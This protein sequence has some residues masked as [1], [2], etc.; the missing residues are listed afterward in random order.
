VEFLD[1]SSHVDPARWL[2]T[3]GEYREF[4]TAASGTAI[5]LKWTLVEH[6]LTHGEPAAVI[7][8]DVDV[9]W[10]ED[11]GH[12]ITAAFKSTPGSHVLVQSQ[13]ANAA[14]H[15][16]C[17]GFVAFRGSARALE[18]ARECGRRNRAD[19]IA[20]GR[21]GYVSDEEVLQGYMGDAAPGEILYL[22]QAAYPV[23]T[24]ANLYRREPLLPSIEAPR[25]LIFHANFVIGI[26][27]KLELLTRVLRELGRLDA[28]LG[29]DDD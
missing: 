20:A 2:D 21:D 7:Y 28:Y 12:D 3:Q 11:A 26:D 22:P 15:L 6:C 13:A 27:A 9:I 14:V 8:S 24:L 17:M 10:L 5:A 23:G 19:L 1:L 4:G 25:P 18:I 16:V 29:F